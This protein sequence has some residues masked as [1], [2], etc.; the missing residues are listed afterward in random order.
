VNILKFEL[1]HNLRKISFRPLVILNRLPSCHPQPKAK[2]FG[3]GIHIPFC[4]PALDAGSSPVWI[5]ACAGMTGGTGM[6]ERK[7]CVSYEFTIFNKFL[8]KPLYIAKL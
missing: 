7:F 3:L 2:R 1:F 8:M 4:H 6:T 5:P